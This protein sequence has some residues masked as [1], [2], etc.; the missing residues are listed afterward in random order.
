M[1]IL[2]SVLL[3][4]S[5]P[6][7][8]RRRGGTAL[9]ETWSRRSGELLKS[10][11]SGDARSRR[12]TRKAR[13]GS[14]TAGQREGPRSRR[15]GGRG[16]T[17]RPFSV[18]L[19]RVL[20][21]VSAWTRSPGARGPPRGS[22]SR[23][24]GAPGRPGRPNLSLRALMRTSASPGPGGGPR[25]GAKTYLPPTPHT[26]S[27]GR[28]R[29][30][31]TRP[32]FPVSLHLRPPRRLDLSPQFFHLPFRLRAQVAQQKTEPIGPVSPGS[33]WKLTC[34]RAR[35]RA[36]RRAVRGNIGMRPP[37]R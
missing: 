4:N 32:R 2:V 29:Q 17:L 9:F 8:R 28:R 36:R 7:R 1:N 18:P 33:A 35:W 26:R 27:I 19:S 13:C 3:S 24:G 20:S 30:V 25:Q 37:G 15:P 22:P 16:R 6:E 23:P 5:R 14:C 34:R 31:S 12:G 10:G 11:C 21:P